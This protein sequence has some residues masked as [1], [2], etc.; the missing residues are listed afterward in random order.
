MYDREY[1]LEELEEK[2]KNVKPFKMVKQ[3]RGSFYEN[4]RW[5]WEENET[6][7]YNVSMVQSLVDQIE[8]SEILTVNQK[9][10][11]ERTI[12]DKITKH[13]DFRNINRGAMNVF[14]M[15]KNGATAFTRGHKLASLQGLKKHALVF[16]DYKEVTKTISVPAIEGVMGGE[17]MSETKTM[18]VYI[19]SLTE[20][21]KSKSRE[22]AR[23]GERVARKD[24]RN[25][26]KLGMIKA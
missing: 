24:L 3:G 7:G 17:S 18:Y 26:H 11:L 21:G 25:L 12:S 19:L 13:G 16:S 14:L 1:T 22:L 15:V 2:V 10:K 5:K 9:I 8:C 4:G 23:Q 20:F 6:E